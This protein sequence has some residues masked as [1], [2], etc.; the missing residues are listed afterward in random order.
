MAA[1]RFG[2]LSLVLIAASLV[3]L[4]WLL[5]SLQLHVSRVFCVSAQFARMPA[6]DEALKDWLKTQ[7]GVIPRTVIAERRGDKLYVRFIMSQTV[8]GNPPFPD[9]SDQCVDLGY[10]PRVDWKDARSEGI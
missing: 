1:R 4:A 9:L 2:I 5:V 8:S 6:D 7:A 3:T 10:G